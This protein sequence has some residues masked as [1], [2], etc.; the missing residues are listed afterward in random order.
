MKS[1]KRVGNM[2]RENARRERA[3][4]GRVGA[5]SQSQSRRTTWI[6]ERRRQL[7]SGGDGRWRSRIRGGRQTAGG[8]GA[9]AE[10]RRVACL[11][12]GWRTTSEVQ[13]QDPRPLAVEV[14]G[15]GVEGW[16]KGGF[17]SGLSRSR[18]RVTGHGSRVRRRSSAMRREG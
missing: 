4:G 3:V 7:D 11:R 1:A 5:V 18:S 12:S 9:D 16:K 10:D 15:G 6:E 13:A 8:K 2:S 14:Q 17:E